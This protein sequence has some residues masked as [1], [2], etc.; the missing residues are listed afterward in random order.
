MWFFC[1]SYHKRNESPERT[2]IVTLPMPHPKKE[3]HLASNR[4]GESHQM[5]TLADRSGSETTSLPVLGSWILVIL[6]FAPLGGIIRP[7][8]KRPW[9]YWVSLTAAG[10]LVLWGVWR[11]RRTFLDALR[12]S[13]SRLLVGLGLLGV[14]LA[15]EL[16]F[17]TRFAVE[18]FH[19]FSF[20][21]L[22]FLWSRRIGTELAGLLMALLGCTAV[23]LLD[24]TFQFYLAC[25]TGDLADILLNFKAAAVGI[26][27][28]G[29]IRPGSW[30]L[31]GT[32]APSWPVKGDWR[33]TEGKGERMGNLLF[34]AALVS[35]LAT[36][37][38]SVQQWGVVIQ[39]PGG[40][41][42]S[43]FSVDGLEESNRTKNYILTPPPTSKD[44]LAWEDHY[45]AEG[46]R[47]LKNRND[48]VTA[49]QFR[50]ALFQ[51]ALLERWYSPILDSHKGH[52]SKEMRRN[53]QKLTP[54]G[55]EAPT[56]FSS[57][58]T[59]ELHQ[60]VSILLTLL[61]AMGAAVLKWPKQWDPS[62]MGMGG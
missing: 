32:E 56:E 5:T 29:I 37:F 54:A 36:W 22:G 12:S 11:L 20:G 23:E 24:E 35:G 8:L 25:R 13:P 9:I 62:P 55:P 49:K 45:Y 33:R 34:M 26:L 30:N 53:I 16:G 39:M 43:R 18:R 61:L 40:T 47:S 28:W 51:D 48:W 52:W 19:F 15:Y 60:P 4:D 1:E 41:F 44:I 31:F 57:G 10:I 3:K 38:L 2:G 6:L 14:F 7:A 21:L 46:L 17:N 50:H 58:P 42:F 59:R 27:F